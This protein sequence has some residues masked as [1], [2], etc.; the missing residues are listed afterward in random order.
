MHRFGGS[1]ESGRIAL[2][3][4]VPQ[5]FAATCRVARVLLQRVE[6]A[7]F[8]VVGVAAWRRDRRR[9]QA[10]AANAGFGLRMK[11]ISASKPTSSSAAPPPSNTFWFL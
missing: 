10:L 5:Q 2:R 1:L 3:V 4:V 6:Q 8:F 11:R 9:D 7:Q